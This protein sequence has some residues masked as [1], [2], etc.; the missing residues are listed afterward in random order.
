MKVKASCLYKAS[1][2]LKLFKKL[3][4]TL[5]CLTLA[6]VTT[7]LTAG[8][9]V[10]ASVVATQTA[11]AVGEERIDIVQQLAE[12]ELLNPKNEAQLLKLGYK[13]VRTVAQSNAV[14][15]YEREIEIVPNGEQPKVAGIKYYV[16]DD[17]DFI[18]PNANLQGRS[19][20]DI[21]PVTPTLNYSYRTDTSDH[22]PLTNEVAVI[23]RAK[24][25]EKELYFLLTNK[26]T[27]T[28]TTPV[29][30]A[31]ITPETL[32]NT[33]YFVQSVKYSP[34]LGFRYAKEQDYLLTL[35][36]KPIGLYDLQTQGTTSVTSKQT[37]PNWNFLSQALAKDYDLIANGF[38]KELAATLDQRLTLA[39]I[40]NTYHSLYEVENKQVLNPTQ[41]QATLNSELFPQ[42]QHSDTH[43]NP[44]LSATD[45]LTE[46]RESDLV[47]LDN[48]SRETLTKNLSDTINTPASNSASDDIIEPEK[49]QTKAE[50]ILTLAFSYTLAHYKNNLDINT[51]DTVQLN[52][53]SKTQQTVKTAKQYAQ[54]LIAYTETA[55]SQ[56]LLQ[57]PRPKASIQTITRTD[58]DSTSLYTIKLSPTKQKIDTVELAL[59]ATLA[60]KAKYIV[61]ANTISTQIENSH[62]IVKY[63]YDPE[64]QYQLE[65]NT[66]LTNTEQ[67]QL[68]QL[69][70]TF[71][72]TDTLL[73]KTLVPTN[74]YRKDPTTGHWI[75]KQQIQLDNTSDLETLSLNDT[76]IQNTYSVTATLEPLKEKTEQL[77]TNLKSQVKVLNT[78][79]GTK[80]SKLQGENG[81][82]Q[83][84]ALQL[85]AS[86]IQATFTSEN[87]V[88]TQVVSK[89]HYENIPKE[90]EYKLQ[91]QLVKL[92][93]TQEQDQIIKTTN[94]V[95]TNTENTNN[96]EVPLGLLPLETGNTYVIYESLIDMTTH[97]TLTEHNERN[98]LANTLVIEN[99]NEVATLPYTGE[100]WTIILTL[101]TLPTLLTLTAILTQILRRKTQVSNK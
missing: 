45:N 82:T 31:K 83:N 5:T 85:K 60:N 71:T 40:R 46:S 30:E 16:Y 6:S 7:A 89:I 69:Q 20:A 88:A 63:K 44:S 4:A 58:N 68:T 94:T 93:N 62:W 100:N 42:S 1:R 79:H 96:I 29:T 59:P 15:S 64:A 39:Q 55:K 97:E 74:A 47:N 10:L 57:N 54:V 49:A 19:F 99:D 26:Y 27:D 87:T 73:G 66:P 78:K 52:T 95:V 72:T 21:T 65:V 37:K 51:L 33:Q 28:V 41:T 80:T 34:Q 3:T 81:A 12:S 48:V 9:V 61:N 38:V 98:N 8:L 67:E 76:Q 18:E 25:A 14:Q 92:G 17:G 36:S 84:Q 90:G 70:V 53:D 91:T 101:I 22:C 13:P 50:Q 77:T 56:G 11:Q 32:S 2:E 23:T 35:L 24:L 43:T 75:L 86:E